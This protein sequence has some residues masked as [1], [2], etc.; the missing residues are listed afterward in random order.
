MSRFIV[1]LLVFVCAVYAQLPPAEVRGFEADVSVETS[2]MPFPV[3]GHMYWDLDQQKER[4]DLD[5]YGQKMIE[6]DDFNAS[7]RFRIQPDPFGGEEQCKRCF[8]DEEMTPMVVPP[9]AVPD[10]T[11]FVN[12]ELCDVWRL[13]LPPFAEMSFYTQQH[14]PYS[15]L[16]AIML[17]TDPFGSTTTVTMTLSNIL[18]YHPPAGVFRTN[19]SV[20]EP[21]KCKAPVDIVLLLDASGS[22]SSTN[23]ALMKKFCY[24][25]ASNITISAD[26]ANFGLVQFSDNS[27]IEYYLSSDESAILSGISNMNQITGGTNMD[28]GLDTAFSVFKSSARKVNQVLIMFT[29]GEP[30]PGNDPV[31]HAKALKDAGIEIYTVGVGSGVNPRILKAIA[32]ED[33]N[34]LQPHYMQASSFTQLIDLLNNVISAACKGDEA[35][36]D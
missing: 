13:K 2:M 3:Q 22:I 32:T 34:E 30:N 5:Y 29:D 31:T 19:S 6:I 20:C 26:D 25:M 23:F 11:D 4:I 1:A 17:T 10:G 24:Q 33:S 7:I 27:R 12:N 18:V 8:L 35:C 36:T 14:E 28:S 15:V 16:R 9:F 21:P